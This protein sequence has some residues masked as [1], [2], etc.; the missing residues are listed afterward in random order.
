MVLRR[1][2]HVGH[3]DEVSACWRAV[4]CRQEFGSG[5]LYPYGEASGEDG[6]D[7]FR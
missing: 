3:C 4:C 6:F 5:P 7:R 2:V 1:R